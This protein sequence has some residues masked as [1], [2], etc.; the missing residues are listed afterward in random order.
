MYPGNETRL[1]EEN[2]IS[3]TA[4]KQQLNTWLYGTETVPGN[5]CPGNNGLTA[6]HALLN[7]NPVSC[8][9]GILVKNGFLCQF[10]FKK[11]TLKN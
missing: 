2:M 6:A 7:N 9:L 5:F 4:K 10:L 8:Q 11:E 3:E 1:L